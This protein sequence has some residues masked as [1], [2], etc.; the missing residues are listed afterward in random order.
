MPMAF[1]LYL[2]FSSPP[3]RIFFSVV[4][5]SLRLPHFAFYHYILAFGFCFFTFTHSTIP[6]QD[7]VALFVI[8][9]TYWTFNGFLWIA[10]GL[11][12]KTSICRII[13]SIFIFKSNRKRTHNQIFFIFEFRSIIPKHSHTQTL[14]WKV[15]FLVKFH[16]PHSSDQF[17]ND[18]DEK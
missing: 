15:E 7:F 9:D 2:F 1:Y 6:L 12:S 16:H 18:S 3:K 5:Q 4:W 11:S 14:P 10:F 17:K 13:T 8:I